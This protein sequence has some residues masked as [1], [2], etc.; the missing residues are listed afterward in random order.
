MKVC[1]VNLSWYDINARQVNFPMEWGVRAGSR[2]AH[3]IKRHIGKGDYIPFPYYLSIAA[4]VLKQNEHEVEIID[5]VASFLTREQITRIIINFTPNLLFFEVSIPS[6]DYDLQYMAYIK[7]LF[8]KCGIAIGGLHGI[9]KNKENHFYYEHPYIDY[10]LYGEYETNLS[11]IANGFDIN[12][13]DLIDMD[14]LPMPCYTDLPF[15]NYSSNSLHLKEPH[16][17]I[18]SSRGCPFHCKF[19]ILPQVMYH[20]KI[21]TYSTDRIIEEIKYVK[22]KFNIH[23]VMFD[24]D[25]FNYSKKRTIDIAENILN[26]GL[27]TLEFGA[28]AR[29]DILDRE[30][31]NILKKANFKGLV[32]GIESVNKKVLEKSGKNLNLDKAIEMIEYTEKIGM[33]YHLTFTFGMEGETQET[34]EETIDFACKSKAVGVQFSIM[35]PFPGTIAYK[36]FKEKGWLLT[37]DLKQFNGFQTSVIK[38]NN[39]SKEDLEY[40]LQRAYREWRNRGL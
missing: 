39:L 3:T 13:T 34:I 26:Y 4:N 16:L 23:S 2:W 29:A 24:D 40:A 18:W 32:Y 35:T 11:L 37:G 10:I 12:E 22:K 15:Y 31:L 19:C 25:C 14:K 36:E 38:T 7:K 8:P 30:T 33:N 17:N 6:L 9:N 28:M 5:G 20:N 1:L 27:N 21:R